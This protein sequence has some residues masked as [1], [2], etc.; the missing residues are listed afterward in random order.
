MPYTGGP[1]GTNGTG[2]GSG[3]RGGSIFYPDSQKGGVVGSSGYV[4][5]TW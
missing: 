1:G 5:I 4:S 3:G 2:Y